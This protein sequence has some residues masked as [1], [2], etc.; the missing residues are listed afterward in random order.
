MSKAK[1]E[2]KRIGK[3]READPSPARKIN[4]APKA[5]PR[6]RTLDSAALTYVERRRES[7]RS[8]L[9][10]IPFR[11]IEPEKPKPAKA[12]KAASS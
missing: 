9:P 5:V 8:L 7:Y 4:K 10:D 12:R 11:P 6:F 3:A 2:G 1:E